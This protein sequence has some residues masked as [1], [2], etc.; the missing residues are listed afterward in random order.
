MVQ[1]ACH[2]VLAR[3]PPRRPVLAWSGRG[4][5]RGPLFVFGQP[6]PESV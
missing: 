5:Q 1:S 3:K 4:R 2:G 6:R